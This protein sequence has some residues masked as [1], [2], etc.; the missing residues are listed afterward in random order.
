MRR[1]ELALLLAGTALLSALAFTV[2]QSV[3][4]PFFLLPFVIWA[5]MR[6]GPRVTLAALAIITAVGTAGT[7]TGI[8]PFGEDVTAAV[9]ATQFAAFVVTL[10]AT[11]AIVYWTTSDVRS[12][13][14]ALARERDFVSTL[15][16]SLAEGVVACDADGRLTTFNDR[17][18]SLHGLP[19]RPIPP[20]EWAEHYDIYRPGTTEHPSKEELPLFRALQGEHV[21]DAEF[22]VAPHGK[23]RVTTSVSGQ[24]IEGRDG[25]VLGAVIAMRDITERKQADAALLEAWQR[26]HSVFTHSPLATA[27]VG[28]DMRLTSVNDAF[29]ELI[30]YSPDELAEMTFADITHPADVALDVELAE[31]LFKGEISQ[32]EIGK[33]YITKSRRQLWVN[34]T[35]SLIRDEDGNPLYGIGLVQDVTERRR[36]EEQLRHLADHDALTGLYNRRRLDQELERQIADSRRYGR[37]AALLLIDLDHFKQINDTLGHTAGDELLERIAKRMARRVRASDVLAR[38]GGDE[39]AVVLPETTPDE[40]EALADAL[41]RAIHGERARASDQRTTASVGIAL[42]DDPEKTAE[43]LFGEADLALYAAKDAGRN[44]VSVFD[45]SKNSVRG[46][47]VHSG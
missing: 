46:T 8:D 12:K 13:Q 41:R 24:R 6:G 45:A 40:A 16:D 38:I 11:G 21:R 37:H 29:S 7:L 22:D 26:W 20:A 1:L 3:L 4:R 31:R 43:Q 28:P 27:L 42:L 33:R 5:A 9:A 15:L 35:A 19:P 32:Y 23:P 39:F 36:F 2:E 10:T 25:E 34:L 30:G 17:A 18:R 44:R 47:E 14:R